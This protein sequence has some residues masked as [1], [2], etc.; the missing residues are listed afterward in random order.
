MIIALAWKQDHLASGVPIRDAQ[1]RSPG[2]PFKRLD[3]LQRHEKRNICGTEPYKSP[4]NK[5]RR[6]SDGGTFREDRS[7]ST[8]KSEEQLDIAT[9]D[10][11]IS[12]V[13]TNPHNFNQ[14][15]SASTTTS[16]TISSNSVTQQDPF[17]NIAQ[18]IAQETTTRNVGHNLDD[19]SL[20]PL[21]PLTHEQGQL[22]IPPTGGYMNNGN[23]N[24]ESN[25]SANA[26]FI[27]V[28]D[29]GF[30]LWAPEQ[31]EA[32]LHESL[33]PPFNEPIIPNMD[34]DFSQA[35]QQPQLLPPPTPSLFPN[36]WYQPTIPSSNIP[37]L[38]QTSS[39]P[40][41]HRTTSQ[42]YTR[43]QLQ[44][45]ERG[46]SGFYQSPPDTVGL[47]QNHVMSEG[48]LAKLQIAFPDFNVSL[49]YAIESLD[50]YW[51]KTA[52]TFPFIHQATLDYHTS[53]AELIILMIIV[54][55]VHTTY[56]R[57]KEFSRLVIQIRGMLFH[58]C[59]LEMPTS[60]LQSFTLCHVYDTW[61][62][63]AESLFVAQ[64]MWPVMSA[65][66][67]KKG[68]GV[69]GKPDLDAQ[70]E[71]AWAAWAKDEERRRSAYC[72]LLMDTQ[73]SAFWNQHCSRQ[74]SIFAHNLNLPCPKSQWEARTASEWLK[75]RRYAPVQNTATSKPKTSKSGYLPGLHPEFTVTVVSEGYSSAIMSAL[76]EEH[77][78]LFK[79]DLDNSLT[80]QMVLI[81]LIAIAW[82]CRTRGG[83]GIRFREGT[84]H[85]RSI[86]F[87]AVIQLRAAYESAVLHMS[88][89]IESRDMRDTF[90]ICIISVLSDIP[91]LHVAAGATA[92][93]GASIGPR[94]YSDAKRRLKLWAKTDDAW[95][96]VWQSVRYLR[97]ALFSE[98]G[99][100]SPW[101]VFNTTL[102]LWGYTTT[103]IHPTSSS[104]ST[105]STIINASETTVLPAPPSSS[106]AY[107][108][109]YNFPTQGNAEAERQ[110]RITSWFQRILNTEGK[111][112]E[113]TEPSSM[114]EVIKDLLEIVCMKL[115]ESKEEVDKDNGILLARLMSSRRGTHKV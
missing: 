60:T 76:S 98:W 103:I 30:G 77:K 41:L 40:P 56:P 18:N 3:L 88:A 22:A 111:L 115:S 21:L 110:R 67:R 96:C 44:S 16:T 47:A 34:F 49:P 38:S 7:S 109:T 80:I 64:C 36:Q 53:P 102:V 72:V 104:S 39:L 70:E 48:L 112:L 66:S 24:T 114:E 62:G 52:P 91:M 84:K 69:L 85:W 1:R 86:V 25:N 17:T 105:N 82:D 108:T 26:D 83:M 43:S 6:I 78:F 20:L 95:T 94:Q 5:R 90:S 35:S 2:K 81:G 55:G 54:G 28:S 101:A 32:L 9:G 107:E 71:G 89:T 58:E 4:P 93:C 13:N 113:L 75:I 11:P 37:S 46:Q 61:Y 19:G 12:T 31:W 23:T 59:G 50:Q 63:N 29:L 14:P 73:L 99:L 27:S 33:A 42:S 79:V 87:S 97:Q 57:R 15:N 106:T 10:P 51:L 100:Y 8:R 68:I 45:D 92:F 65:H 74:L